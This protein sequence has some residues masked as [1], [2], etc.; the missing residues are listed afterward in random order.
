MADPGST[1]LATIS[2]GTSLAGTGKEQG[3]WTEV[4]LEGWIFSSSVKPSSRD[5]KDLV[6]STDDGEN[7]RAEPNGDILARVR[8]GMLLDKLSARGSWIRV[9][10]TGWVSSSALAAPKAAKAPSKSAKPAPEPAK[11]APAAA[12]ADS[13]PRERVEVAHAAPLFASPGGDTT[14]ALRTGL[15][16][17]QVATAGDWVRVEFDGWV[18]ASDIRA[19][20]AGVLQGVTV[21]EIRANPDRY[22]G[23]TIEWHVQ[24]ISVQV[25]DELRPEIPAGQSYMLARG[26][27]PENGFVYVMLNKSQEDAVRAL[28]PLAPLTIRAVVRA[29][30]TRYLA[31][32]VVDLVSFQPGA[33]TN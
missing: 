6:V 22:V 17:R 1:T 20:P 31:T 19:S 10:R 9:R 26:P 29:A 11:A 7:L 21:A 32:P 2:S 15:P 30:R 24:Y 5:G 27:L 13:D 14:A 12:A 28:R 25:A 16:G 4:R 23:Q 18:R 8:T 3:G 33:E